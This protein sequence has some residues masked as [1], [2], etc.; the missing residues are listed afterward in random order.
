MVMKDMI[1]EINERLVLS[2]EKQRKTEAEL[3]STKDALSVAIKDL[4]TVKDDLAITMEALMI[5]D[6]ILQKEMLQL[7]NAPYIHTC[8][9]CYAMNTNNK[10]ISYDKLLYSSTNTEGGG[11]DISTGTFTSPFPGSY[12]VS[13][14]MYAD[15]YFTDH[16]V[17][18][19][20]RKNKVKIDESEIYSHYTGPSGWATD[21][22]KAF[23][24]KTNK[25]RK[26]KPTLF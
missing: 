25:K 19:F 24:K 18:I 12:M 11:L 16:A 13:W 5:Q 6:Q 7:S 26:P 9:Y 10:R 21:Q 22:G 2:E 15:N 4:S 3:A 17:N 8:G 23:N 20:L 1:F 14:S